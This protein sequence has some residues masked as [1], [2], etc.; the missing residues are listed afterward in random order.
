MKKMMGTFGI[1]LLGTMAM[2]SSIGV[3]LLDGIMYY[4]LEA[5]AVA[6]VGV[7]F[8]ISLLGLFVF[9]KAVRKKMKRYRLLCCLVTLSGMATGVLV[10]LNNCVPV[11][12]GIAKVCFVVAVLIIGASAFIYNLHFFIHGEKKNISAP[13]LGQYSVNEFF[14]NYARE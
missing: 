7:V 12:N 10:A 8:L 6:I 1:V 4:L 2:G 11:L 13:I 14:G 5:K 3:S 9:R